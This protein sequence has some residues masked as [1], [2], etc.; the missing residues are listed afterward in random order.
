MCFRTRIEELKSKEPIRNIERLPPDLILA[1]KETKNR[2]ETDFGYIPKLSE[3]LYILSYELKTPN[4]CLNA[5]CNNYA[6]F[7]LTKYNY[8]SKVCADND[9]IRNSKIQE[10]RLPQIDY[11]EV[12]KKSNATR[13]TNGSWGDI[14]KRIIET[15]TK[16][17]WHE[18]NRIAMQNKTEETIAKQVNKRKQTNL[19]RYG[20]IHSGGVGRSI[21]KNLTV[22]GISYN[23]LQGYEDILIYE[24]IEEGILP[25]DIEPCNRL[26]RHSFEYFINGISHRYH[27]DIYVKSNN[28]YYEAKSDYW[29]NKEK[30]IVDLKSKCVTKP[31]EMRIYD[32]KY[33]KEI[34]RKIVESNNQV[35]T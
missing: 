27:P 30:E 18:T 11:H 34:R 12:V 3:C 19:S 26:F 16:N 35:E 21:Q 13:K 10:K 5:S 25:E 4:K 20:S 23:N 7:N 31:F 8:C 9:P 6:K 1:V 14:S 32:G 29:Y 24:L 2:F 15:R 17:G 33:A 22:Y 28:T